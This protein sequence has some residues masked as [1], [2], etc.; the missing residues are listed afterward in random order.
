MS[1]RQ[2]FAVLDVVFKADGQEP[3]DFNLA[4]Q[5][6]LTD[7]LDV[8]AGSRQSLDGGHQFQ[9]DGNLDDEDVRLADH[10]ND[11]A[12]L[13]CATLGDDYFDAVVELGRDT[14]RTELCL[15]RHTPQDTD[16][17]FLCGELRTFQG[18][19][20]FAVPENRR[21]Y[22]H[23]QSEVDFEKPEPVIFFAPA[24]AGLQLAFDLHRPEI[25]VVVSGA[26]NRILRGR[27]EFV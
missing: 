2:L 17:D 9:L 1:Y 7:R 18:Q 22:E 3:A 8:V 19:R 5:L 16:R 24:E 6:G 26:L 10:L 15:D 23:L 21:Q 27:L 11:E 4:G 14:D 20:N 25:D 13:P 12:D